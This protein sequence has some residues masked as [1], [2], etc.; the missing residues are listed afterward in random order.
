MP[1]TISSPAP[2][3]NGWWRGRLWAV[4]LALGVLAIVV[5]TFR[6]ISKV[7]WSTE[8][9][10]HGPIVLAIGVW[11]LV[12]Q[13]PVLTRN[14]VPGNPRIGWP[15]LVAALGGYFMARLVGSITIESGMMYLALVATLYLFVGAAAMRMAWFPIAFLLFV[16]PP[17]GSVVAA[18]TQP[19]RLEISQQAVNLLALFGYP[20][21]RAGLIIYV[22]QYVLEVK[23]ACGG[24]NSIISLT[25][26]G[27]F[28]AYVR[29]NANVRYVAV[30]FVAITA[31]AVLANFVRVIILILTTYYLGDRAAQGFL[32]QFAGLTMFTVAIGGVM[33][34][35]AL[36]GPLRRML[37]GAAA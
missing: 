17:P 8:Q 31:M 18:A 21:A 36:A 27:L 14:A 11:L 28:Y 23:A 9:G 33:L 19:L 6:G 10:A 1:A 20:V 35:D 2:S 13:W 26:I 22:D 25:A 5:P 30:L 24:L 7:S 29:H 12:R 16:L 15:L 32:H 3:A 37:R 34:F 4:P